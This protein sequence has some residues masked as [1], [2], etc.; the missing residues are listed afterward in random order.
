M[1]AAKLDWVQA[2]SDYLKDSKLSYQDIADKYGVSKTAVEK[3]ATRDG[4]STVRQQLA[5]QSIEVLSSDIV[6]ERAEANKRHTTIYRNM[7]SLAAGYLTLA[8]RNFE[9]YLQNHPDDAD[10][11]YRNNKEI[12]S[13]YNMQ[14]LL[15]SLKLAIE[16]ERVT[17]NLPITVTRNEITGADGNP[18]FEETNI[19]ELYNLVERTTKAL[20]QANSDKDSKPGT[21]PREIPSQQ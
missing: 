6:D 4:W 2:Q 16:G 3:H 14:A 11:D 7:Q 5:K 1:A 13:P 12:L 21:S 20:A 15:T 19:D 9:K 10:F 18:L 8:Y 17:L